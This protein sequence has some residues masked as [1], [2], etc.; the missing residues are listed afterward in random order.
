MAFYAFNAYFFGKFDLWMGIV[1]VLAFVVYMVVNV[2]NMKK[3]P[4]AEEPKAEE[5]SSEPAPEEEPKPIDQ[6]Q[7]EEQEQPE[8]EQEQAP[9][10]DVIEAKP[11]E[12]KESKG[13]SLRDEIR[14]AILAF[15][16]DEEDE[17]DD[18][19]V[20]VRDEAKHTKFVDSN[21]FFEESP[22][23]VMGVISS[24][25]PTRIRLIKPR[26]MI[27]KED[28]FLNNEASFIHNLPK[29]L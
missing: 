28:S 18:D 13:A 14:N 12:G 21:Y 22:R 23:K 5:M 9:E 19:E 24:K 2:I 20:L 25:A 1:L 10:P 6:E 7:P 29:I 11:K 27:W 3:N 8:S 4:E 17:D 16:S 15:D 26:I